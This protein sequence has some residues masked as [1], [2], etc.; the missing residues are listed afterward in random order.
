LQQ[1]QRQLALFCLAQANATLSLWLAPQYRF[2]YSA[3][4]TATYTAS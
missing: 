2:L 3:I 1:G 4:K